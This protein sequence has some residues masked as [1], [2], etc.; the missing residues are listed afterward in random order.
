MKPFH[1]LSHEEILVLN[2]EQLTDSIRVG[3]LENGI[4]IPITLPDALRMSEY[5]GYEQPASAV[6]VYCPFAGGYN[7]PT[8]GY[9]SEAQAQEAMKGLVVLGSDYR[10]NRSVPYIR[11][12]AYPQ[13]KIVILGDSPA[14]SKAA[15]LKAS[16]E[17]T[18][19]EEFDKYKETCLEKFAAVRQ[20]DYDRKVK[21]EIRKEYLRLAGGNEDIAKAFYEKTGKGAWPNED[22]SI[23]P[24]LH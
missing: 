4:S 7:E 6:R 2:S 23:L 10:N 17:E 8:C 24:S 14:L 5:R 12:D 9:L 22:G 20:A 13:I 3:A 21:A 1:Q 19:S 15:E 16:Q 11:L 18:S